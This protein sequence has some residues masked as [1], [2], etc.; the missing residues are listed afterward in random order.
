MPNFSN[1]IKLVKLHQTLSPPI[2]P[3]YHTLAHRSENMENTLE[4]ILEIL[5]YT[6]PSLIVFVTAYALLKSLLNNE[7]KK[8]QLKLRMNNQK[9]VL[10]LRLQAYERLT[11]LLERIKPHSLIERIA[12][13]G[14]SAAQL[15]Q[16]LVIAIRSEYEHNLSQQIYVSMKTWQTVTLVKENMIQMINA[17][18]SRTPKQATAADLSKIILNH[19]LESEEEEPAQQALDVLKQEVIKL[20]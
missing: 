14:M 18:G 9:E 8:T 7:L 19:V 17:I 11:L 3:F 10:P 6:L 12:E 2:S 15:R 5:K 16:A 20:Y 1:Y 4:T 13:P